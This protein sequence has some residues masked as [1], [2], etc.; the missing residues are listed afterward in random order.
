MPDPSQ[1]L[2]FQRH[3]IVVFLMLMWEVIVLFVDFADLFT[4]TVELFMN[5]H[6]HIM[7]SERSIR[8]NSCI[9]E[10]VLPLSHPIAVRDRRGLDR[11]DLQ[12]PSMQSVYITTNVVSSK[13][14]QAKCT[15][16]NI[17]QLMTFNEVDT[18]IY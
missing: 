16:Y 6:L 18:R 10:Y 5:C 11:M 17:I 15:R 14:A 9:Y 13:P 8:N 3:N 4:I 1:D 7:S 12:L 2:D